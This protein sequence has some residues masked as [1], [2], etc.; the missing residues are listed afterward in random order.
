MLMIVLAVLLIISF[1]FYVW[2]LFI[3]HIHAVRS[4]SMTLAYIYHSYSIYIIIGFGIIA[5]IYH[6]NRKFPSAIAT[7]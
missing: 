2:K 3:P 1:F 7:K 6:I 4:V 5:G